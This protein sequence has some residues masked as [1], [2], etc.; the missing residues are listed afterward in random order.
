MSEECSN[1]HINMNKVLNHWWNKSNLKKEEFLFVGIA[2]PGS[3]YPKYW[4]RWEEVVWELAD[5][6]TLKSY[7]AVSS[8]AKIQ[9]SIIFHLFI[10]VTCMYLI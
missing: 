8:K 3:G 4:Q 10:W 5:M 1:W 2:K 7:L 9:Q 6:L